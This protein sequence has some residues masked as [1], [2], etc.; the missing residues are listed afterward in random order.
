VIA[1][2]GEYG[3]FGE[4]AILRRF[5]ATAET[6]PCKSFLD[7]FEAVASGAAET[8]VAPVENSL[9]GSITDVYDLLR[10]HD[11]FVTGE[12]CHPVDLCLMALPGQPLTAI[13][14]VLSHPAALGQCDAYLRQLGVEVVATYDTAGSAKM[15]REQEMQ[16]VAAVAGAGAAERYGL[17]V[18]ARSIQSVAHN[19]TRFVVLRRH[20]AEQQPGPTRTMLVM[21][22]THQPGALH[23]A[24]GALARRN[25]NLLKLESRPSRHRPWEYVFYLDF[26]GHRDEAPVAEALAEL[27]THTA[28]CKVLGSFARDLSQA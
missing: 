4:E 2:Q 6:M 22:L 9:H 18:L 17:E 8:G 3:A 12:I 1:F 5:G 21:A 14:R 23:Q 28:F 19:T 25:L 7:V 24:L 10:Q 15:V 20:P 27:A 13:R 26:E 16:G 11:L